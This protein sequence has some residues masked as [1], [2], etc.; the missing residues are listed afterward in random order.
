VFRQFEAPSAYDPAR[1]V[2]AMKK[3]EGAAGT[4]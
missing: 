2:A 3:A 4:R 1:F